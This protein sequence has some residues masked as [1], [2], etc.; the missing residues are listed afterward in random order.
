[1]CLWLPRSPVSTSKVCSCTKL[2]PISLN[3]SCAEGGGG[4]GVPKSVELGNQVIVS[5]HW[6]FCISCVGNTWQEN[7]ILIIP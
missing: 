1:M 2:S 3:G 6:M 7:Q 5:R 4:G